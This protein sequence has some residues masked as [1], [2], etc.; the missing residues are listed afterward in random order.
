MFLH[1]YVIL[2]LKS[3]RDISHNQYEKFKKVYTR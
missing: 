2:D 3:K 1:T